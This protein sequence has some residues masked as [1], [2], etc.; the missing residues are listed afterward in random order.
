MMFRMTS[1]LKARRHKKKTPRVSQY[2]GRLTVVLF[3]TV[4][5]NSIDKNHESS[6]D[7]D[8]VGKMLASLAPWKI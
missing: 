1:Q 7:S 4:S 2:K 5:L 8:Q 3:M 6:M